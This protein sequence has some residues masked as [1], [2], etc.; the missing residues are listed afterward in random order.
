MT[1]LGLLFARA[2]GKDAFSGAIKSARIWTKE[3]SFWTRNIPKK[4]PSNTL[5]L[6]SI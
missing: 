4:L 2:Q 3:K 1:Y 5:N 6:W